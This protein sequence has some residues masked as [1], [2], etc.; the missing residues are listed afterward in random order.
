MKVALLGLLQSGKSTLLAAISGVEIPPVGSTNIQEGM[1]SVPDERVDWLAEVYQRKKKVYATIDCLDVPGLSFTDEHTRA[2]ARRLIGQVRTVD[3][4]AL[5]IRK[6]ENPQVPAYRHGLNPQKD[7]IE[8]RTEILLA[9]LE[10]VSTRIERLEKQLK[11]PGKEQA[12]DEA[13]LALHRRLQEA[14]ESEKSIRSVI[15][16]EEELELI[17]S[18]GFL[19][20]KPMIIV[21]NLGEE[22]LAGELNLDVNGTVPV[23]AVCARLEREL[24]QL[25]AQSRAEFMADLGLA[26]RA[27]DKFVG[28]CYSA[29][30]L[31]S[32]LT[33]GSD[34][35]R[36][37]PIKR[38]TIALEAAGKVHTDMKRGFIRAQTMAFAELKEY[39][40]EKE[41]KA[42]GKV[43]LEG[44]EY[45][46]QDGDVIKFRFNV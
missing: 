20:L 1:V 34:E 33:I 32:F 21:V 6:F 2:A 42:A 4:L 27:I 45:V 37:W 35:V 46:V 17:R 16:S 38:D 15:E 44:K 30:G 3:M 14:I 8:L 41:L 26:Q 23:V 39:G 5:V 36:A 43:R 18:L 9:D 19:T 25:D 10:L 28:S 13:E 24:S 40:S 12:H 31:I 7:L 29:L 11:K 22:Q